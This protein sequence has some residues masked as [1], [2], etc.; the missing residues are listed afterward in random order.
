MGR[1]LGV[2]E[3][4]DRRS[5]ADQAIFGF[6]PAA[7]GLPWGYG[8]SRFSAIR[9]VAAIQTIGAANNMDHAS[10]AEDRSCTCAGYAHLD[11]RGGQPN[12]LNG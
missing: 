2:A 9:M 1:A 7:V 8:Y 10:R 6:A 3:A 12:A 4:L 11:A 5:A